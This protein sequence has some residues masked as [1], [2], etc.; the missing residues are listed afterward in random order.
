MRIPYFVLL[1]IFF[2]SCSLIPP[3]PS[4]PTIQ[5]TVLSSATASPLPSVTSTP[6]TPTMSP[7][8]TPDPRFFRDDF[9]E[10]LDAEWTWVREDPKNWSLQA[11]PG[12]LQINVA[13]GYVNAQTNP[14]LLLRPAPEGNFQ[15]T[16]EI[17]FR[18]SRN[19]QFAGLILY[20]N[21]SNFIQA[22]RAYCNSIG[23]VGSGLY[24]NYYK[25]GKLVQPDFGQ[26]FQEI[27]PLLLRL[28]RRDKTFTFEASTDGKVWF[29]IGS[30]T[31]DLNPLQIGLVT[32][33]RLRGE[34]PPALFE[35]F[36]VQSLQ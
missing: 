25:D 31:G 18:P 22:G 3:P 1:A 30:H 2:S 36:E 5:I 21:N 19:Y 8:P 15:I 11:L 4:V 24:M 10:A 33:Q 32:G 12:A 7:T 17:T 14:N 29:V 26:L 9:N 16:T 28:S 6:V 20:E 23:C 34:N 35:Y 13:G 27:D